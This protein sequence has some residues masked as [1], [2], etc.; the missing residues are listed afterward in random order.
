MYDEELERAMLYY[1]IFEKK[2]TEGLKVNIDDF[3]NVRNMQIYKA[4][5]ELKQSR[6][7]IN[8]ISIKNK[9]EGKDTEI[10]QYISKIAES[11]FGTS[12]EYTYKEIKRLSKKRQAL[13]T[14]KEFLEKINNTN[15]TEDIEI[16]IE[17]EIKQLRDINQEEEKEKTFK[18]IVLETD[19]LIEEKLKQG[20]KYKNRYFTGI[21][22]LDKATNGL[23]EQELTIIGARP[24]TGKTTLALKIAYNIAIENIKVGIISLE[25]SETQ[26]VQ[27]MIA[28]LARVDSNKIRDGMLTDTEKVAVTEASMKIYDLPFF[29]NT[30]AKNIQDIE[31]YARRLKNKEDLGL[32]IIDYIQLIKSINKTNS[33]EQ[34]VAEITRT[35]KLLSLELK[36]P[37]IGLC[38]LN[39]NAARNKPILADLRESGAIEQ[40]ADNVIFLYKKEE[41]TEPKNIEDI[42][43]DLQK[44]RAGPL[45]ETVVRFN[46]QISEFTNLV[47]R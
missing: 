32:L 18:Q 25:M 31:T 38:Q 34:E 36:I 2:E 10:L 9:I 23:H 30:K 27:K 26:L 7:E 24:G 29:I 5:E 11:R 13:K 42:V 35:L 44:Q 3:F 43:I 17:K 1:L 16:T 47:R 22:D 45:T 33:R 39:R 12:L 46:K 4:I 14:N 20:T 19:E 41:N 28:R 37:I 6:E 15:F 40:D 21:F 8:L